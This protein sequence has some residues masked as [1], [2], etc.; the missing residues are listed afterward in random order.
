MDVRNN[1]R[2]SVDQPRYRLVVAT[3]APLAPSAQPQ[4]E[5]VA[6][7]IKMLSA[8]APIGWPISRQY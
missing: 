1:D 5:M 4:G 8:V 6:T 3:T 7:R 2:Q